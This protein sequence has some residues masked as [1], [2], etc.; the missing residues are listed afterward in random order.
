MATL[1]SPKIVTNGLVMY[2]DAGNNR[3]YVSGSANWNDLSRTNNTGSLINGP[4]FSSA[5]GG[6]LSFDGSNDYIYLPPNFF[7]FDTG[8]PFSVSVWFKTTS[9][10]TILGVNAA[11][12]PDG[13][14]SW[15]PAIYVGSD[16]KLHTSCFWGGE[17]NNQSISSLSVNNGVFYNATVTFASTVHKSYLNGEL[18]ATLVKGQTSFAATYYY[19]VG[20]GQANSWPSAGNRYFNGIIPNFMFYTRALSDAEVRQNY[21]ATK[22]RFGL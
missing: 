22:G 5:N 20:A 17:V 13:A 7:D 11:S 12:T 2:L 18:F 1:Y 15:V 16:N 19:S 14:S 3:S 6:V 8:T 4:T 21:H 9:T 10:G